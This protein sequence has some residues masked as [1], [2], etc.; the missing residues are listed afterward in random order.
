MTFHEKNQNFYYIVDFK[1]ST[2]NAYWDEKRL[3]KRDRKSSI[4]SKY[5]VFA[6]DEAV[7]LVICIALDIIEYIV[8]ILMLPIVGDVFDMFGIVACLLMFRWVGIISFFELIPGA[9]IAP[10]FIITWLMW[11]SI[12]KKSEREKQASLQKKW[13]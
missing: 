7:S 9:D 8:A 5:F 1:N 6:E 2:C 11:Y 13:V 10:I 12:K 3:N 4:V